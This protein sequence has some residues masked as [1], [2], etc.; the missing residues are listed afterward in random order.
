MW[1]ILKADNHKRGE[2]VKVLWQA[3]VPA[4]GFRAALESAWNHDDLGFTLKAFRDYFDLIQAFKDAAFPVDHL[5]ETLTVW[6]GERVG[7]TPGISWT[8]NRDIACRFAC[9]W[10]S[11]LTT[12]PRVLRA[13]VSRSEVLAHLQHRDEEEIV[14]P[15]T[16]YPI[17]EIDG[18]A[19]EWQ[20]TAEQETKKRVEQ[21]ALARAQ[22]VGAD[23][24]EAAIKSGARE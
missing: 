4:A 16:V 2:I 21:A 18:A 5:P 19:R 8:L 20:A 17:A 24:T 13:T 10:L 9:L 15:V 12:P 1:L 22:N 3:R 7:S 6:R 14:L 23:P 11:P